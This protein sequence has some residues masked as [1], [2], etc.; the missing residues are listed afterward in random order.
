MHCDESVLQLVKRLCISIYNE[1]P[2]RDGLP[3]NQQFL[4]KTTSLAYAILLKKSNHPI[5]L[6]DD[7]TYNPLHEL[8][9]RRFEMKIL[10]KTQTDKERSKRFD[11]CVDKIETEDLLSSE[12]MQALFIL[13]VSLK[14]SVPPKEESDCNVIGW[15]IQSALDDY[16]PYRI[17]SNEMMRL[18][19]SLT[20]LFDSKSNT[21]MSRNPY[22]PSFMSGEV[23][24][25]NK[26]QFLKLLSSNLQDQVNTRPSM[27]HQESHST[28]NIFSSL[29]IKKPVMQTSS[30]LPSLMKLHQTQKRTVIPKRSGNI[31]QNVYEKPIFIKSLSWDHFGK[32]LDSTQQ[33]RPFASD[34]PSAFLHMLAVQAIQKGDNFDVEIIKTAQLIADIKLLLGGTSSPTFHYNEELMSFSMVKNVTVENV[35][36]VTMLASV[37]GFLECGTCYA[38]LKFLCC[39]DTE[40]FNMKFNGFVFQVSF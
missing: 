29:L 16:Q 38:R 18:P 32:P 15:G 17:V 4:R 6:P 23:Q 22:M 12:L 8:Q 14:D 25:A 9:F 13:L 37:Q 36:P 28:H 40:N 24:T 2:S 31:L 34:C 10:A 20:N 39:N 30:R 11:Q 5:E 19:S 27:Y 7:D 26:F 33:E 3:F 21:G 1:T 35:A